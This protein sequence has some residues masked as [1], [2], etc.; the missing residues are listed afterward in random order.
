MTRNAI[1]SLLNRF[2]GDL[3]CA[4]VKKKKKEKSLFHIP[5]C[6]T[7]HRVNL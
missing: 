3:Q 5:D 2:T 6:D 1:N 4:S 7:K